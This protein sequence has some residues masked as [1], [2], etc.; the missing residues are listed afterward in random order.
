[1]AE[2][3]PMREASPR[4]LFVTRTDSSSRP[5]SPRLMTYTM[6]NARSDSMMVMTRTT[7]LIGFST[8][9]TTRKN[10]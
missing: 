10:A 1:M 2:P 6:S 9:K 3:K 7:M 5:L 8:G 4:M